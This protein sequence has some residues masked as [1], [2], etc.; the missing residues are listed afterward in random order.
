M[1]VQCV[2]LGP[3]YATSADSTGAEMIKIVQTPGLIIILN[4]DLTYRQIFLD[5]RALEVRPQ[6]S[7]DGVL[8]RAIG[9]ATR[10]SWR[11][12]DST[13]A[14]GSIMMAIRTPKACG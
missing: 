7:L 4:P 1:N 14:P 8:G 10:W 3:G 6:P 2:P 5:G 12:S 13:I 9:M 11:V